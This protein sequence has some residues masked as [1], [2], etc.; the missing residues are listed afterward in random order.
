M[1]QLTLE[2]SA[3]QRNNLTLQLRSATCSTSSQLLQTTRRS[4]TDHARGTTPSEARA[5]LRPKPRQPGPRG[6]PAAPVGYGFPSTR[7]PP[8][9]L[10]QCTEP[11]PGARGTGHAG[12][13]PGNTCSPG[14]RGARS[15]HPVTG[16]S[17][18]LI[19]GDKQEAAR[20][21]RVGG[22][23]ETWDDARNP[24]ETERGRV[25]SAPAPPGQGQAQ[26]PRWGPTPAPALSD[27]RRRQSHGSADPQARGSANGNATAG[28]GPGR[29]ETA[30]ARSPRSGA[31]RR[32]SRRAAGGRRPEALRRRPGRSPPLHRHTAFPYEL[33]QRQVR[34]LIA[35]PTMRR[36]ER[37]PEVTPCDFRSSPRPQKYGGPRP[38]SARCDGA[39]HNSPRSP[40]LSF[41]YGAVR[42]G[43]V[44]P[45]VA[46]PRR[47]TGQEPGT[48]VRTL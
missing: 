25:G 24:E 23:N 26:G 9:A 39:P 4:T 2:T 35:A 7:S 12:A 42:R 37:V 44:R 8:T 31:S 5:A 18:G 28:A 43:S 11:L 38:G 29:A 20:T 32:D 41:A 6:R 33:V 48:A 22:L 47:E 34:H 3:T 16:S 14:T 1:A 27:S 15:A 36:S 13:L 19:G 30:A 40:G 10:P 46:V 21:G 17:A 45:A